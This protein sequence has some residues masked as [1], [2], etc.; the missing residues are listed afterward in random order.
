MENEKY[1]IVNM[2]ICSFENRNGVLATNLNKY[3]DRLCVFDKQNNRV[4]DVGTNHQYEYIKII[5]MKYLSSENNNL[6]I[7]EGK[8]YAC[9]PYTTLLNLEVDSKTL[10][11]CG[12]IIQLLESGI[13]FP[14]GNNELTNEQY[15]EVINQSKNNTKTMKMLKK[16]K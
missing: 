4:I 11:K 12:K 10:N 9:I 3:H 5:N 16:R 7:E 6:K 15:L 14:D 2:H 8:R 1:Q 13:I